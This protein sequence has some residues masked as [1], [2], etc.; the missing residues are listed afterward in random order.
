[1]KRPSLLLPIAA[2]EWR[3]QLRSPVLWVGFALFF[4]LAFG[5]TTVDQIQIGARGNVHINAPYAIL[6]TTAIMTVFA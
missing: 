3:L 6:Q 1:M 4:L 2:F 5:A